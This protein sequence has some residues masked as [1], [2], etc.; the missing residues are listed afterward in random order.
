MTNDME[1]NEFATLMRLAKRVLWSDR[2]TRRSIQAHK[3][4]IVPS[5]F[6][7]DIPSV[8]D[9]ERSFEFNEPNGPYNSA[10]IFDP[11]AM[12]RFLDTIVVYSGEFDPPREGD[13]NEPEGFFWKN[14]AF[15]YC[16]AMAYYCII[17]HLK[18]ETVLEIGSG[19]STLVALEA[20]RK[21]GGGKL[22]CVEP[23]PLPWLGKLQGVTVIKEPAQKLAPDFFNQALGAGD[24]LFIDSTHTVKAGSDCLHLYLRVLPRIES[25]IVVHAHDIY[26]PFPL[27]RSDFDRHIY[28]TEQYLLYA[29]M[30]D[31]AKINVLF[32]SAFGSTLL[33]ESLVELMGGK[34]PVGGASFWFRLGGSK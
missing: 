7:S 1:P 23:F 26:L 11:E 15:S 16:D 28:W 12:R 14:P 5:N 31:N 27:P 21:N 8:E 13:A 2:D 25:D 20:L 19:F 10:E 29:Y 22:M 17:R 18:P 32:G 9:I 33:R 3:I 24:I 4:N 34:W 30:L 6:Y